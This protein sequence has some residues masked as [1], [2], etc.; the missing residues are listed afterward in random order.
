MM[1]ADNVRLTEDFRRREMRL[2]QGLKTGKLDLTD[3][4][5]SDSDDEDSDSDEEAH[6]EEEKPRSKSCCSCKSRPAVDS[7]VSFLFVYLVQKVDETKNAFVD[8]RE[9]SKIETV[10]CVRPM[11]MS[12][13]NE[14]NRCTPSY[15]LPTET[16]VTIDNNDEI[17]SFNF[18][19]VFEGHERENAN[20]KAIYEGLEL[21]K[22]VLDA[23][24]NNTNISVICY[25]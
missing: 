24:D 20:A 22:Q 13:L 14:S 3:E 17:E 11:N 19:K 21:K 1:R 18:D 16:I 10:L 12:E 4:E 25:G 7:K 2:R 8:E 6:F 23:L 15:D 5:D 9:K